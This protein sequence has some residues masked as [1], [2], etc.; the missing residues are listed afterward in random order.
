M[1]VRSDFDVVIVGA[2]V[3]GGAIGNRLARDGL[4]ILML[5]R[6]Q[7][8]ADRIRGEW[9]APLGVDE[10]MQLGLLDELLAA[11]G[12]YVSKQLFSGMACRSRRRAPGR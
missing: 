10:A 2:G 6:T 12:H 8:H 4:S 3:A 5:E 1:T 11:G 7:V 9:L